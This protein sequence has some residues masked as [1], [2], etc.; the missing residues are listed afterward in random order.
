M[1]VE[2]CATQ[3][4]SS[5]SFKHGGGNTYV[6]RET[7]VQ[8]RLTIVTPNPNGVGDDCD[9]KVFLRMSKQ[10]ELGQTWG[11]IISLGPTLGPISRGSPLL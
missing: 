7:L 1:A 9:S 3:S 8:T 4:N 11:S 2:A 6:R 10:S 5:R